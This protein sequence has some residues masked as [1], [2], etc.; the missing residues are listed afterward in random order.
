MM[1]SYEMGT[2][3]DE[4]QQ[5]QQALTNAVPNSGLLDYNTQNPGNMMSTHGLL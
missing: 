4:S 3:M 5:K 2:Y 1:T